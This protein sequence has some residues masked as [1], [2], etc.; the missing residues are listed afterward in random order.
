MVLHIPSA[1]EYFY[2]YC[3]SRLEQLQDRQ[4]IHLFALYIDLRVYDKACTELAGHDEKLELAT[5]IEEQYLSE[6]A[7]NHR[8]SEVSQ[9]GEYFPIELDQNVEV[10]FRHK[11]DSLDENLN[12]YLFLEVYAF[13]LDK[14]REYFAIFKESQAFRDLE[15]EITRQERLY[16]VLV[17][18]KMIDLQ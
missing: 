16:E 15:T 13:V 10:L 6:A 3:Q 4:A 7:K 11:F 12:E 5:A 8:S 1:V 14:L 18:S 17:E 9:S 2:S